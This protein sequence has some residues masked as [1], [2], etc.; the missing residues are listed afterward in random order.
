MKLKLNKTM[1]NNYKAIFGAEHY[2]DL[3]KYDSFVFVISGPVDN[4]T[5]AARYQGS[6]GG[7]LTTG[8]KKKQEQFGRLTI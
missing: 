2:R 1:K 8:G 7:K 5:V 3:I 4:K 6:P